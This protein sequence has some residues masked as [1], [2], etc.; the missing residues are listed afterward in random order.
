MKKFQNDLYLNEQKYFLVCFYCLCFRNCIIQNIQ[1]FSPNYTDYFCLSLG[2]YLRLKA[3]C[4]IFFI[5]LSYLFQRQLYMMLESACC[6]NTYLWKSRFKSVYA[7]LWGQRD[8][9]A[10]YLLIIINTADFLKLFKG[11]HQQL[12]FFS[13]SR[14]QLMG[15]STLICY[16]R[17]W[18]FVNYFLFYPILYIRLHTFLPHLFSFDVW[19]SNSW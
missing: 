16:I 14:I 3:F 12:R 11:I 1:F 9:V 13:C 18:K 8:P 15:K 19:H 2:K 7:F 17:K 10:I 6:S 5:A 4:Y